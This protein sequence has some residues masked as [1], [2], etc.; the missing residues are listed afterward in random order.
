AIMGADDIAALVA[1]T[2]ATPPPADEKDDDAIMGADDI[3]ALVAQTQATPTPPVEIEDDDDAL[4]GA[5]D[6]AALVA[7]TQIAPP[8]VEKQEDNSIMS[9][10][11][12][13]SL[14]T[15][16]QTE[17]AEEKED[18]SIMSADDIAA[19]VAQNEQS[20]E[21]DNDDAIMEADDIAALVA[22]SQTTPKTADIDE[23]D[24]SIMN[25]DDIAKLVAQSQNENEVEPDA[26]QTDIL[27]GQEQPDSDAILSQDDIQDLLSGSGMDS[28]KDEDIQENE[29]ESLFN[30]P[31]PTQDTSAS[32]DVMS[33]E[34]IAKMFEPNSQTPVQSMPQEP[35]QDELNPAEMAAMLKEA[36][37]ELEET[38]AVPAHEEPEI[39]QE[40]QANR[41]AQLDALLSTTTNLTDA[42][43][44]DTPKSKSIFDEEESNLQFTPPTDFSE[45]P[46]SKNLQKFIVAAVITIVLTGGGYGI[47]QY[48][49]KSKTNTP[50]TIQWAMT[51][52]LNNKTSLR[53]QFSLGENLPWGGVSV[54]AS[55]ISKTSA[56]NSISK[57]YGKDL[58][59]QKS[60]TTKETIKVKVNKVGDQLFYCDYAIKKNDK[61]YLKRT[62]YLLL[63][64]K[65]TIRV[66]FVNSSTKAEDA[67]LS[68]KS[69]QWADI[70]KGF[71]S[72]FDTKL[73][74]V[75]EESF[76][77]AAKFF[78]DSVNTKQ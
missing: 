20:S 36:N 76:N 19:L 18:D 60:E 65:T 4:M 27:S 55:S 23:D 52:L 45:K 58:V 56:S 61:Y 72:K 26:N 47:Y 24:D 8:E 35:R 78:I 25:A 44:D 37:E 30:S 62:A 16:S 33:D 59:I 5:D 70:K 75:T 57:H 38:Q 22:Q 77:S 32:N 51:P 17:A 6:I 28:Q 40:I 14:V 49:Q 48:L 53:S 2:Q 73:G 7:Q 68:S 31:P 34:A 12:I 11:D 66:D 71:T 42:F 9:A 41:Q 74:T 1:Q 15:Q 3:A 21:Q 50:E 39:D 46:K 64:S 13:A 67:Q 43:E 63:D 29:I 10:D 69:K 54:F